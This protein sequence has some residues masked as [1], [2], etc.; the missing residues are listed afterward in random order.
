MLGDYLFHKNADGSYTITDTK[1]ADGSTVAVGH[2]SDRNGIQH[3]TNVDKF[4]F[5]RGGSSLVLDL[6]TTKPVPMDDRV[7]LTG[8]GPV[9]TIAVSTLLANDIDFQNANLSGGTL[10]LNWVGD[11]V[12]GTATLNA[13]HTS[14]TF[15]V[16]AGYSGPLEFSYKVRDAKTDPA[17]YVYIP[18]DPTIAGEIRKAACCWYRLVRRTDPDYAGAVVSGCGGRAEG[19]A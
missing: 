17:P 7:T 15:T 12:G 4:S 14:I 8:A 18:S 1:N 13:S 9:Y 5:Q 6:G 19:M 2:V 11:A 16:A 3:V 10:K